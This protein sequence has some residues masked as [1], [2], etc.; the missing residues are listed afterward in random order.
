M[1]L[2]E[3]QYLDLLSKL[4][5][6]PY[7]E[8]RTGTGTHSLFGH[9]MRFDLSQGFPL[10]TTKQVHLRSI[11]VELLWFLRGDTNVKY[12]QDN[13]V[14]IW[15]EWARKYSL[16][17]EVVFIDPVL[18]SYEPY[19]GDFKFTGITQYY[20][21][22]S[23]E[24]RLLKTWE[25]MMKR[26]YDPN[27]H[28]YKFYGALGV[29]VC[30]EWHDPLQFIA[31]VQYIPH[32]FYKLNNWNNFDLDKDYFGSNQ[33][34]KDTCVW[35]R[36]DENNK[37]TKVSKPISVTDNFGIERLYLSIVDAANDTGVSKTSLL[38]FLH[39]GFPE[40]VKGN[41]R[42][43][44]GYEFNFKEVEGKLTRLKLIE[45]GDMGNIYPYQWRNFGG[46]HYSKG[47]DQ[48]SWVINEIKTNPDSRRLIVSSWNPHDHVIG[49]AAL[50]PCH[51]LFQFYV[52]NG[53][54]SCQLYQRSADVFLGVP[55]NIA[56]Y[57]LLTHIIAQ[58]T[59]L[60][61]GE[62]I[63]TGGDVH[64][65]SNHVDQAKEQ[66]SRT[67]YQFPTLCI[68]PRPYMELCVGD[69][70]VENYKHHPK[71]SAPVAV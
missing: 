49:D 68:S 65:Y 13:K 54:L 39:Q 23:I 40:V 47:F 7:K 28:N 53:K 34:S 20:P 46:D 8:D 45:D 59:G 42:N 17:R 26:C 51:T 57:A 37:Y 3:Q 71:I 69:I 21:T 9:Q 50:P 11:V 6:A 5:E 2:Q 24:Y 14:S 4:L 19:T 66:I 36:K 32:W 41:N 16:N 58:E 30:K 25:R 44:I 62:F 43:Y 38:R 29:S 31:D 67:P 60:D 1:N 10:L 63:W 70:A 35:L 48:I 22:D 56:S 27:Q 61:V 52:Q 55:F 33:Y 64:L 18:K 15:D 12:L